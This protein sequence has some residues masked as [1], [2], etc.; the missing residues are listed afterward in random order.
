MSFISIESIK[1]RLLTDDDY[2]Q[3]YEIM[4]I[5]ADDF[6]QT[7]EDDPAKTSRWGHH[8]FCKDDGSALTYD[9]EKPHEHKCPLC[10][11]MY[12]SD[13]LDGVWVYYYRN[14]A[15]LTLMKSAVVYAI[16]KEEKYKTIYET[17]LSYYVDQYESFVLH[18][19]EGLEF[20][21]IEEM[22][23]GC[24]RILP[25][26]LNESILMNRVIFSAEIMKD[27]LDEA[28]L[29]RFKE[30]F[31]PQVYALL[32]PQVIAIH[33]ISCWV[34]STIGSMGLFAGNQEMI[35]FAFKGEYNMGRQLREGVTADN[36]WHEGSIHYN[37][38]TLEGVTSLT[39]FAKTYGY[40]FGEELD[41]VENM[42][43]SAYDYAFMNHRLPNPNDG[44]PDVNLKTYSYIYS[45][46]TKVFGYDSQI[47]KLL[48]SILAKDSERGP[49]PLSKPY[50]YKNRL[51]YE[52][53]ILLPD[54]ELTGTEVANDASM[55]FETSNFALL[56]N[57]HWNVFYKYGHNDP[58]H[59][60]PDKMTIE[61]MVGDQ[62]LAKDISNAGYGSVICNEW[63]RVTASHNTV[64][65]DGENHTSVEEGQLLSFKSDSAS[66]KAEGVYEDVEF[67]RDIKLLPHGFEDVFLTKSADVRTYDYIFHIDGIL[68][69]E[70]ASQAASLGYTNNGYQHITDVQRLTTQA[71]T[72]TLQWHIG[73]EDFD[74]TFEVDGHEVY[75]AK[76][77][78]NPISN[79][80]K[81]II[82]RKVAKEA[83]FKQTWKQSE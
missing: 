52:R 34:N 4:A 7:F 77:P 38:F 32:S 13:L 21:T 70:V 69:T 15:V 42:L 3:M 44:W 1:K 73:D 82:V 27:Y 72:L 80:R 58:S 40:D 5:E 47:G 53:F 24:G 76:S 39:L 65:V 16:T 66:A 57:D 29:S 59:A 45:I 22:K 64:V 26:G 8:Y 30:V 35:D 12:Q 23:W 20:D 2:K 43:L 68:V 6:F 18:N 10:G 51:S 19:K 25:Q 60:H 28:L 31:I 81:T 75:T 37:F 50:Y 49:L 9:P 61:V 55:N 83:T 56:K 74:W 78:D 36:F 11:T 17:I 71:G 48:N 33:N 67:Q 63:H 14:N 41:I 62:I 46:G 79:W 54:F